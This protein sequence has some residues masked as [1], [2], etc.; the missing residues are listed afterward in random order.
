MRIVAVALVVF[1]LISVTGGHGFLVPSE[2]E[3]SR[4]DQAQ[5]PRPA[6]A[7]EGSP[8]SEAALENAVRA[9]PEDWG[10]HV[11]L[12]EASAA[13]GHLPERARWYE[14]WLTAEPDTG[15]SSPGRQAT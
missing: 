2:V 10:R 15:S 5:S 6:L 14:A 8:K 12:I 11:E 13:T 9:E 1:L 4:A 7:A 3:G